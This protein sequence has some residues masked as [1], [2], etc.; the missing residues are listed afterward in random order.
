MAPIDIILQETLQIL[1]DPAWQG[2]GVVVSSALSAIA[3]YK[4]GKTRIT[5]PKYKKMPFSMRT[6][7]T[8]SCLGK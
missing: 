7:S 4:S 5:S 6:I 1:R 8:L 2:V 3:F